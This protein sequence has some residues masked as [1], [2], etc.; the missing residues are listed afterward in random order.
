[1][2]ELED[3]SHHIHDRISSLQRMLDLS[4]VALPQQKIRQLGKELYTLETLL[5]DF[6]NCVDRQK[7]HLKQLKELD[8]SIQNNVEKLNH[9]KDHVP[10]QMAVRKGPVNDSDRVVNRTEEA[11]VQQAQT[12]KVKKRSKNYIREIEFIT[13]AE[14]ESIPQYMKGRVSYE[15]LNAAVQSINTAVTAKY[16][17]LHQS[18]KTLNNHARKLYQGFKEQETKDTEGQYFVVDDDILKFAE[19]KVDK[20]F[21]GLLNMLRHC[22]RLREGSAGM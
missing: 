7:N 12:E 19:T 21:R 2:N 5:E 9:L 8:T 17:I 11:V 16:K 10:A 3:L 20:P 18:V 1:M 13:V 22:Q 6:E 4:V 14:F 15:K